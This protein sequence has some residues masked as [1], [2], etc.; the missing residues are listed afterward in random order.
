[1]GIM[2]SRGFSVYPR[3]SE[4]PTR[5]QSTPEVP[6]VSTGILSKI[7][8]G[9]VTGFNGEQMCINLGFVDVSMM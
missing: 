2:N 5:Q 6:M 7:S 3:H 8:N 1:M 9:L 4:L